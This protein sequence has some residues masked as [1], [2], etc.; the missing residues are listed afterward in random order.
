MLMLLVVAVLI[1][2]EIEISFGLKPYIYLHPECYDDVNHGD[3]ELDKDDYPPK[4][5]KD[6]EKGKDMAKNKTIAICGLC[7]NTETSLPKMKKKL[8]SLGSK[9]KDYEIVLFE[10]DSTDNTRELIKEWCKENDKVILLECDEAKDCKLN[11]KHGYDGSNNRRLEKMAN[12]RERYLKYVKEKEFDYMLVVDMDLEGNQVIDGIFNS[13]GHTDQD[14]GAIFINGR[15]AWPIIQCSHLYDSLAFIPEN[16]PD[17]DL[18]LPATGRNK[19]NLLLANLNLYNKTELHEVKSAFA[20]FG[21]YKVPAL[22]NCSYIGNNNL[23]EHVNLNICMYKQG[24]KLY[25]NPLWK[26]Y[27]NRQGP[28]TGGPLTNFSI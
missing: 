2:W 16:I 21:L 23:C 9:F 27:F 12:F 6:I 8:E 11:E 14:W 28:Q 24:E 19:F 17:N 22:K 3:I 4:I 5:F 15:V 13:I 1:L 20:G 18:E 26:G 7:R 10:N 25:I